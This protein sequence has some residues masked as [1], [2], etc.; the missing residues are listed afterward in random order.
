MKFNEL[1]KH[2]KT[3]E[4]KKN[5][6]IFHEG[7]KCQNICYINYGSVTISTITSMEKEEIIQILGDNDLFGDLLI[8]SDY[9][10]YLGNVI[11]NKKSS[12]TFIPK[13]K[14]IELFQQ[15]KELLETFLNIVSNKSQNIKKQNKLLAHKSIPDRLLYYFS[16]LS[17][18]QK[19]KTILI[20]QITKISKE[21][22]LP[23]ESISRVIK[24]LTEKGIIIKNKKH[25]T[26]L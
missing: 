10:A 12:V 2:F 26:L 4:Y 17:K 1:Y 9:P 16:L 6:I 8:F 14:L 19:S 13:D 7:E 21:L 20:P 15:D 23:R 5:N 3:I 11:T 25:I 18:E 22:S 24:E